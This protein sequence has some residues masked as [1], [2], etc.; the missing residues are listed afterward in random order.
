M[1]RLIHRDT[2]NDFW[3]HESRLDEYLAAGHRYPPPPAWPPK[4]E[5]KTAAPRKTARKT[6]AKTAK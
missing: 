4:P 1:I 5:E 6:A 2:G 3:V